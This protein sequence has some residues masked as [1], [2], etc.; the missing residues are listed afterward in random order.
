MGSDTTPVVCLRGTPVSP[1]LAR[2]PLVLLAEDVRSV[3]RRHGSAEEE[4]SRF[5][6]AIAAASS[7]LAALTER[8]D[9]TEAETILAFQVAMLDDPVVTGP[10]LTA[11]AAPMAGWLSTRFG[12]KWV[13]STGMF[14]EALSLFWISRVLYVDL[15]IS[16][17]TPALMRVRLRNQR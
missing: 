9:D 5:R 16:A 15:P 7:E 13:V 8:A 6:A 17:I 2:G 11:I 12:A 1:G 10:A 14:F 3:V 4:S